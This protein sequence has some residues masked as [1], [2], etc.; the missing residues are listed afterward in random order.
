[1]FLRTGQQRVSRRKRTT[2]GTRRPDSASVLS[3]FVWTGF[4][5]TELA[6]LSALLEC[7]AQAVGARACLLWELAPGSDLDSSHPTGRFWIQAQW[8]A[9]GVTQPFREAPLVGSVIGDAVRS[10]RSIVVDDIFTDPRVNSAAVDTLASSGVKQMCSAPITFADGARGA[11]TLYRNSGP[12]VRRETSLVEELAALL[13]ALYQTIRDKVAFEILQQVNGVLYRA[14]EAEANTV[15]AT[16]AQAHDSLTP[17]D[18]VC[19][20]IAS[21]FN[22]V[23]TSI[24]LRD[25]TSL[26]PRFQLRAA[27]WSGQV[28]PDSYLGIESEGP[29][30]WVL[31][32]GRALVIH[33]LANVD[34]DQIPLRR[35][36]PGLSVPHL[37]GLERQVRR[38]LNLQPE[39]ASPP[40][41][42]MAVPIGS[43]YEV[44]G[45]LRC[46][47]ASPG[48]HYFGGRELLLLD[49]VAKQVLHYWRRYIGQRSIVQ[50]NEA[51]HNLVTSIGTL[52]AFVHKQLEHTVPDEQE[53]F[54][55][56]LR[57]TEHV[58]PGAQIMDVRLLN[59]TRDS[60]LFTATHGR[61]WQEGTPPEIQARRR[62]TFPIDGPSA[63]AHVFRTRQVYKVKDVRSDPHYDETFPNAS[64]VMVAPIALESEFFG[65]I[66]IRRIGSSDF[67]PHSDQIALVLGQQLGLY[68][69]LGTTI[70]RVRGAERALQ[71]VIHEQNQILHD[72]EHQLKSPV[73]QAQARADAALRNLPEGDPRRRSLLA[74]SGLAA[75]AL[76]VVRNLD[77]FSKLA[78]EEPIRIKLSKLSYPELVRML[79]EAASDQEL[80]VESRRALRFDVDRDSFRD[81]Q[82]H[83]VNADAR[84][85]EQAVNNLLDNAAKYSFPESSVR[86]YGGIT[87][88]GRFHIS[89]CNH[90]LKLLPSDIRKCGE[91]GFRGEAAMATTGEGS[92]IGL[93]IVK[94][95]MLAHGGD[96]HVSATTAEELTDVKLLLPFAEK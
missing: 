37:A 32:H 92:G 15:G 75:K 7:I 53:I 95:I 58:V 93:W 38:A 61:A 89:V 77:L 9:E 71:R 28:R 44:L 12:F 87:G 16:T 54:H 41:C 91:R 8:L 25:P 34:R 14:N 27:V 39:V 88:G 6:G 79:I 43:A 73:I 22:C 51:W 70:Q 17:L 94:S 29:T 65:V 69:F 4:K 46:C 13:P 2:D 72:L 10:N 86:I 68:H 57:I 80:L 82:L 74:V 26:N 66:D 78:R 33:D 85:L 42:L 5:Q 52:N 50:E 60:F 63:A 81:L 64:G 24:F 96:L 76:R 36:Y 90:G 83:T 35:Q 18:N 11:M 45:V 3:R 1:M 31:A 56:A 55:E 40:L 49:M 84:L 19:R 48:P 21:T 59:D 47:T 62:K 30:A 23:E 20:C 67:P